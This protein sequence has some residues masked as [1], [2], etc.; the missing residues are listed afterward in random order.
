M[1]GEFIKV[2]MISSSGSEGINLKNVRFVHITEP[3]WHPVRMEQVIGRAKRICSHKDLPKEL[4]TVDVFLYLMTIT[5]SQRAKSI[6]LSTN[7]ISRIDGK[8]VV[9]TDQTLYEISSIKE[10]ITQNILKAVKESAFDCRLHS[11]S[12]SDEKIKC[13]TFGD[14]VS[15]SSFASVPSIENE[16]KDEEVFINREAVEIKT[17]IIEIGKKEY[18]YDPMTG[19]LYDKESIINKNPILVGKL[20]K[21]GETFNLNLL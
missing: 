4:R 20:E 21:K 10:E 14:R 2:L 5:D 8:S 13:F 16:V 7:D 12:S 18:A 15:S 9:S 11:S 3:Y 1:Y 6:E 19:N 17:K